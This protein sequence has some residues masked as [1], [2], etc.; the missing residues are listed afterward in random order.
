MTSK[1]SIRHLT[2]ASHAPQANASERV[3]RSV[4]AAIRS[5]INTEQSDWDRKLDE[6][7]SALRTATHA[8]TKTSPHYAVFGQHFIKHAGAYRLL[9]TLQG[10]S[11]GEIEVLP[12]PDFRT[13]MHHDIQE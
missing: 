3:N 6:I 10:L 11:T 13:L 9:R 4:L 1:F 8:S 5:Y 12:P 7:E 2:S